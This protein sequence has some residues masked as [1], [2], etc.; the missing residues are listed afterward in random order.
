MPVKCSGGQK[1]R[2]FVTSSRVRIAQCG[3]K[4]VEAKKLPPKKGKK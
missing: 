1:P 3:G 2:F 4:T